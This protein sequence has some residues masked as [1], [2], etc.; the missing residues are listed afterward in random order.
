M[1]EVLLIEKKTEDQFRSFVIQGR[2]IE[3]AGA[4]Y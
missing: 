3:F 2:D 1:V 4:L